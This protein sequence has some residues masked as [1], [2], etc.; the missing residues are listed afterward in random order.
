M[1]INS[2]KKVFKYIKNS[3]IIVYI[4]KLLFTKAFLSRFVLTS[5]FFFRNIF[6]YNTKMVYIY[7]KFEY[8][9]VSN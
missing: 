2:S 6:Y 5:L 7:Y 9:T 4:P 1:F 8:F 3:Q